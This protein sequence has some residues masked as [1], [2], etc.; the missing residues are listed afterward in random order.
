MLTIDGQDMM[1]YRQEFADEPACKAAAIVAQSDLPD[2]LII[3]EAAGISS[4]GRTISF[5][6]RPPGDPV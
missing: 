3:L 1:R 6:C 5:E 4:E 2:L